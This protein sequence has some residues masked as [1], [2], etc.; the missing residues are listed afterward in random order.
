MSRD[1]RKRTLGHVSVTTGTDVSHKEAIRQWRVLC[2]LDHSATEASL[3]IRIAII[4]RLIYVRILDP[5][6]LSAL[7]YL[8]FLEGPLPIER[9]SG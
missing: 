1:V 3:Y 4:P 2:V 5:S 9:M 8:N 7:S 6:M